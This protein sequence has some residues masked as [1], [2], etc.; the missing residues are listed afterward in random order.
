MSILADEGL[1]VPTKEAKLCLEILN[2][3]G[4]AKVK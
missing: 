1:T 4:I 2:L 3:H